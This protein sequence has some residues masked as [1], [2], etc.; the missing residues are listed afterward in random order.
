MIMNEQVK[1]MI[2]ELR[3]V[4]KNLTVLRDLFQND[5]DYFD[6]D[7]RK[8]ITEFNIIFDG[9]MD[10]IESKI[11]SFVRFIEKSFAPSPADI[12]KKK[13]LEKLHVDFPDFDSWASD[14]RVALLNREVKSFEEMH[15]K[16]EVKRFA[17]QPT[18]SID[19]PTPEKPYPVTYN[20]EYCRPSAIELF[21]EKYPVSTFRDTLHEIANALY[22]NNA[23]PLNEYIENDNSSKPRF[24]TDPDLYRIPVKIGED[25]YTETNLHSQG[26]MKTICLLLD[27]YA[28]D[29]SKVSIYL[30]KISSK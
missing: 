14:V 1:S 3:Q 7:D 8:R 30:R 12:A 5:K 23:T 16:S 17:K 13:A 25:I 15:N 6:V 22:Q 18:I 9:K 11:N 19:N 4:T 24:S 2:E 29:Y 21:G 10:Q 27:I 26:V 20:F 28:V